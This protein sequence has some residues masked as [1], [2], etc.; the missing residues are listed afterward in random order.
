MTE[1][2]R[3]LTGWTLRGIQKGELR[4]FFDPRMHDPGGKHL[5][6]EPVRGGGIEEGEA[7]IRRLARHP[8]TARFVT[9]KLVKRFV[10]DEPPAMLVE[11]ASRTFSATGG[12]IRE[13]LRTIFSAPEFYAPDYRAAKFKTPL[14]FVAS[15]ARASSADVR[16]ARPLARAVAE[17]GMPLYLSSPPTGYGDGADAWV[18]TNALVSRLSFAVE[19]ASGSIRGVHV[20]PSRWSAAEDDSLDLTEQLAG[21][22]LS[23]TRVS[24]QTLATIRQEAGGDPRRVAS[25]LIGSPEFQRR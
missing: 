5:L 6:A 3:V 8:A 1:L 9:T 25:L 21:T 20:S 17:M 10:A 18:S 22:F 19:I 12:D 24:D 7:V 15:A 11:R 2:A 4:F 14:E 16:D 23:A 13:V